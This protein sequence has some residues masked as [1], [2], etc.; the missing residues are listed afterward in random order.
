MMS[1]ASS[2]VGTASSSTTK[3]GSSVVVTSRAPRTSVSGASSTW[4]RRV[5][6]PTSATKAWNGVEV[7]SSSRKDGVE[8]TGAS[9]GSIASSFPT[10]ANDDGVESTMTKGASS[11]FASSSW[12]MGASSWGRTS[13]NKLVGPTSARWAWTVAK[14]GGASG[15][16]LRA[17]AWRAASS[18]SSCAIL[19]ANSALAAARAFAAASRFISWTRANSFANSVACSTLTAADRSAFGG[20]P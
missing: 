9:S 16:L 4:S 19:A 14:A 8:S 17:S 15:P 18:A 3:S 10:A 20:G 12:A 1:A 6:G 7:S 5:L 13:L 2:G 11:S